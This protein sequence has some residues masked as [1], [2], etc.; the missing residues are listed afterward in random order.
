MP[1]PL[2]QFVAEVC[3]NPATNRI[4]NRDVQ[5]LVVDDQGILGSSREKPTLFQPGQ[6]LGYE[7]LEHRLSRVVDT[8]K[9]L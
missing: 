2:L 6:L 5:N 3:E 8:S 9:F 1:I 7:R 4:L